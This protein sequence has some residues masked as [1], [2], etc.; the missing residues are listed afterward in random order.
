MRDLRQPLGQRALARRPVR[1]ETRWCSLCG[2]E[3]WLVGQIPAR[4]VKTL[5]PWERRCS[6][7][8][9]R[10]WAMRPRAWSPR[11]SAAG[12]RCCN[13]RRR[14]SLRHNP[15]PCT[16][17]PPQRAMEGWVQLLGAAAQ[18]GLAS[19]KEAAVVGCVGLGSAASLRSRTC[20]STHQRQWLRRNRNGCR[21]S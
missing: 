13:S 7:E 19:L 16:Q 8:R 4:D 3:Q 2:F 11:R 6:I 17:A 1:F 10:C 5:E 12:H 20:C 9:T 15:T 18:T 21:R 14:R